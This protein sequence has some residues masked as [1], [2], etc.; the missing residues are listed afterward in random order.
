MADVEG[1]PHCVK[2]H[3]G[4]DVSNYSI[5]YRQL[6]NLVSGAG[7]QQSGAEM[8]GRMLGMICV[9]HGRARDILEKLACDEA[10]HLD[11]GMPLYDAVEKLYRETWEAMDGVGLGFSLLLPEQAGHLDRCQALVDWARGFLRGLALVGVDGGHDMALV[12]RHALRDI[13]RVAECSPSDVV[14]DEEDYEEACEFVWV[15]ALLVREMLADRVP[16]G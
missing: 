14:G 10:S 6:Q 1:D 13:A 4:R 5:G 2:W 3:W 11:A 15:A 7:L 12:G 9:D 16:D 8:H